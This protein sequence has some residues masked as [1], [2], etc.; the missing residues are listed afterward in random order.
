M[1]NFKTLLSLVWL[2][3]LVIVERFQIAIYINIQIISVS[4]FHF[5]AAKR[6]KNSLQICGV[7]N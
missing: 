4:L 7:I 3:D 2:I 6:L 5:L 1:M